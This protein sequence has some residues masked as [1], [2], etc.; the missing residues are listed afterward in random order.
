MRLKPRV[1]GNHAEIVRALRQVGCTVQILAGVGRGTPD[2]LV[3]FRSFNFLMELKDGHLAP[4]RKCL[5][6]EEREWHAGWRGQVAI[7][8]S[9]TDAL[10]VIGL[11]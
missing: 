9:V 5:N 10:R 1:D 7:V 11:A 3:G 2:L 8:E 6:E 4:S